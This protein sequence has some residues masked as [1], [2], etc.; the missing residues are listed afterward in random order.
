MPHYTLIASETQNSDQKLE[1]VGLRT[2]GLAVL[3]VVI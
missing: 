2:H 1:G 3:L